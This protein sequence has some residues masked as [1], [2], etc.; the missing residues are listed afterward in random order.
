MARSLPFDAGSLLR[1]VYA[2][3]EEFGGIEP[4]FYECCFRVNDIDIYV[5]YDAKKFPEF[6]IHSSRFSAVAI[7]T[8]DGVGRVTIVEGGDEISEFSS[9]LARLCSPCSC[10]AGHLY[11]TLLRQ[12]QPLKCSCESSLLKCIEESFTSTSKCPLTNSKQL[13]TTS[14]GGLLKYA[15]SEFHLRWRLQSTIS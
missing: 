15:L 6:R 11:V 10:R 2:N 1:L 9:A 14:R 12:S 13:S 8:P 7:L 3:A 5:V 4:M